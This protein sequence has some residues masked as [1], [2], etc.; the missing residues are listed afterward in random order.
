MYVS[1]TF[2]FERLVMLQS[3]RIEIYTAR[4]TD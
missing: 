3:L 4:P 2:D 1:L